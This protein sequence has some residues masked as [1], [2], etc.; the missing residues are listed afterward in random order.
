ML[1]DVHSASGRVPEWLRHESRRLAGAVR[2]HPG[3]VFHRHRD[4]ARSQEGMEEDLDLHLPR[5]AAFVVVVLDR[6]P[7]RLDEPH[8]FRAQEVEAILGRQARGSRPAGAGAFR[9]DPR[10]PSSTPLPRCRSRRGRPGFRS[11]GGPSRRRRT[12]TR[13]SSSQ[14]RRSRSIGGSPRPFGRPRADPSG[15]AV[16][17]SGRCRRSSSG[18]AGP[19]T[20]RACPSPDRGSWSCRSSFPCRIRRR[21]I[22]RILCRKRRATRRGVWRGS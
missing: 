7:A 19:R 18:S 10:G 2:D 12:R 11:G 16:H 22:R 13:G 17:P 4:V 3:D 21:S 5:P 8:H 9:E 6:D 15:T 1:V 14:H 20:D